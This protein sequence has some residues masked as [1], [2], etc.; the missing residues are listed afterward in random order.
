MHSQITI[1][2][3][4]V[5]RLVP[6]IRNGPMAVSALT[7]AELIES[8]V[9][10][11]SAD[12]SL[13]TTQIHAALGPELDF[14]LVKKAVSKATKR[15]A[16]Q[17]SAL[18]EAPVVVP[19]PKPA[20]G[21]DDQAAKPSK[22]AMKK[23]AAVAEALK[24]AEVSMMTALK[25]RYQERWMV[26]LHGTAAETKAFIDRAAM[27][28]ISG[29]LEQDEG[30]SKERVDADVATLHYLL[31][32]GSP[33]DLPEADRSK[34]ESQLDKLK[35]FLS[36][37]FAKPKPAPFVL[38]PTFQGYRQGFVFKTGALG[39]GY[40]HEAWFL[41]AAACFESA[42][43]NDVR[44]GEESPEIDFDLIKDTPLTKICDEISDTKSLD[45][46][47]AKASILATAAAGG[48]S[49]MDDMD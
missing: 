9:R 37:S 33:F 15:M 35:Q 25:A 3:R 18:P 42:A 11:R 4:A 7:E 14:G 27:L 40:Y 45:R 34:A 12:G 29:T 41:G 21:V 17:G 26:A 20:S 39:L 32:P 8:V 44:T 28:A 31:L 16:Q 10:L 1:Q 22:Q 30:L 6:K 24:A 36:K 2:P 19:V 13:T 43:P 48:G 23:A 5:R 46:A 49:A 38:Q 47:M